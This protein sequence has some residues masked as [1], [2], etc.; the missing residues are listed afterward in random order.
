MSSGF[1]FSIDA[2]F[3]HRTS[4][5]LTRTDTPPSR[6]TMTIHS[7]LATAGRV[8]QMI[9]EE[10]WPNVEYIDTEAFMDAVLIKDNKTLFEKAL[11]DLGF[12]DQL[13]S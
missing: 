4:V 2:E 3:T 9:Q 8:K 6:A 10:V 5:P 13:H 1:K 11:M 12:G 7:G